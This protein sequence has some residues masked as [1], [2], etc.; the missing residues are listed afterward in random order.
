M[1]PSVATEEPSP[2]APPNQNYSHNHTHNNSRQRHDEHEAADDE[3]QRR[4]AKRPRTMTSTE[5]IDSTITRPG[6]VRINVTGAFIVD[7][8]ASTPTQASD[9]GRV[10]PSHHETSDIRLPNHTAIVSHIAVDVG[11]IPFAS[12]PQCFLGTN[13]SELSLS[14]HRVLL[15]IGIDRRLSGQARLLFPRGRFHG[16]RGSPQL[17]TLRDGSHRRLHRV[18]EAAARQAQGAQRVAIA[19]AVRH[20]YRRRRIQVLRPYPG[21]IRGRGLARGRDGMP[22]SW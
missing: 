20:G 21:G 22:H 15:P 12:P 2:A 1:T 10:S 6:S 5:D 18:Y 4:T 11:A 17:P 7:P 9:N 14:N 3:Q 13:C 8:D 16:P 19:G